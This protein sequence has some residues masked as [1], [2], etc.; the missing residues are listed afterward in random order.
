MMKFV[1]SVSSN[2][3]LFNSWRTYLHEIIEMKEKDRFAFQ[4]FLLVETSNI[5]I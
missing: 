4:V 2:E 1:Q 5:N 3:M